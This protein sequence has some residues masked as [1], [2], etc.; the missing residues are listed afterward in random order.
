MGHHVWFSGFSKKF[1]RTHLSMIMQI[2]KKSQNIGLK[3]FSCIVA[4]PSNLI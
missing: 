3:Y 4:I 1:S 2:K